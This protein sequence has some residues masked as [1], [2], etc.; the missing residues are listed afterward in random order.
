MGVY[1]YVIGLQL[2]HNNKPVMI[3]CYI[4]TI[5]C[6][7]QLSACTTKHNKPVKN[8]EIQQTKPNTFKA[9]T[10]PQNISK[11]HYRQKCNSNR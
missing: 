7:L 5:I 1:N 3:A 9:D 10:I 4:I 11:K 8:V 2:N 6:A